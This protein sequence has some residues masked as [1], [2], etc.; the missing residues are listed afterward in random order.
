MPKNTKDAS[1]NISISKFKR[2]IS[3]LSLA[4]D[5]DST[6]VKVVEKKVV[7]TC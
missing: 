7:E 6:N 1:G 2:V 3:N 5:H 4:D